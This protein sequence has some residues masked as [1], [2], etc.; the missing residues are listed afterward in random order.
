MNPRTPSLQGRVRYHSLIGEILF[1]SGFS[2]IFLTVMIYSSKALKSHHVLYK[3]LNLLL[4]LDP[5]TEKAIYK[6]LILKNCICQICFTSSCRNMCS[7]KEIHKVVN[8]LTLERPLGGFRNLYLSLHLNSRWVCRIVIEF[9][10]A[11]FSSLEEILI[12]STDSSVAT[13]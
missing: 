12:S 9:S 4:H 7:V 6:I 3:S 11:L 2:L 13:N 1:Y 8:G 5:G 10:F